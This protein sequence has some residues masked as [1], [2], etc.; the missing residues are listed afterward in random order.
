MQAQQ[1]GTWRYTASINFEYYF[2]ALLGVVKG[3][4]G[5]SATPMPYEC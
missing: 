1:A 4:E 2:E 5:L 3:H